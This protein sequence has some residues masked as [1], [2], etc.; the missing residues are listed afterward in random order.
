MD[1]QSGDSK[2]EV[3]G[4]GIGDSGRETGTRMRL[5]KRKFGQVELCCTAYVI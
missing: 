2:E 5:T 4:E 1:E 3:I